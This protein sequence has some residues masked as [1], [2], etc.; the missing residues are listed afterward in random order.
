MQLN[1]AGFVFLSFSLTAYISNAPT[2][3]SDRRNDT[4][5]N[6]RKEKKRKNQASFSEVILPD[7][8]INEFK[9]KSGRK[10]ILSPDSVMQTEETFKHSVQCHFK[11]CLQHRWTSGTPYVTQSHTRG[12]QPVQGGRNLTRMSCD[13]TVWRDFDAPLGVTPGVLDWLEVRHMKQL[14]VSCV[15]RRQSTKCSITRK[16]KRVCVFPHAGYACRDAP[17]SGARCE[18]HR[19]EC[20][21]FYLS[22]LLLW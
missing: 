7:L 9:K 8:T 20:F 22:I 5:R 16:D 11:V 2:S 13:N 1:R 21:G 15:E 14:D 12:S 10:R 18:S 6:A 17:F 3:Q 19:E 4:R